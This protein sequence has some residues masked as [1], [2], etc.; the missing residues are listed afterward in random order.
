MPLLPFAVA[1]RWREETIISGGAETA[2]TAGPLLFSRPDAQDYLEVAAWYRGLGDYPSADAVLKRALKDL[3]ASALSPLVYYYLASD[4]RAEQDA[5]G[6]RSFAAEAAAASYHKVFPQRLSDA[7]VL[8]EAI[9]QSPV[10]ARAK[11]YLGNFFFA[12]GR[13]EDAARL[14][15]Q[16]L[17]GGFDYS[18]LDRNL[19]V[20]AWRV[21]RDRK[22]AA[23]F[24][25]QA[26]QL[27]PGDYRLYT[28]LD[29]IYAQ[30]GDTAHRA[31]VFA[32]AP[33]AVLDRDTVR[34]RRALLDVE[35][36]RYDQ[37]LVLLTGH[38]FKPWE[39]GEVVRRIYVRANLE[40]GKSKLRARR[41]QEAEAAFRRALEYPADLGVGKPDKP[42]DEQA[43]Y[44][45]GEALEAEG[46][47]NGARQA[48]GE[49]VAEGKA[50]GPFGRDSSGEPQV[51]AA[52]ALDKLG[53]TSEGQK[54]LND[55]ASGPS[56]KNAGKN[57][58]AYDFYVAGLAERARDHAHQA[59][60]DFRRA[61][62]LDPSLW[63]A[64]LE[65]GNRE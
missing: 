49:A 41:A 44:W 36:R 50:A 33:A 43:L 6:A 13:Y 23:G 59:G 26:L 18:V 32:K 42:H 54:I 31:D 51:C 47:R 9:A 17:G 52:L 37:A 22:A 39:G 45:L 46:K 11:Y 60:S 19:G 30:L 15:F 40:Q 10:D 27:A 24:Y 4:A 58:G 61:L 16:A 56:K 7:L 63:E 34:V 38:R 64:R 57:A 12:R 1:E 5:T 35:Q 14:W 55:L 2:E 48:W 28:D 29:E 3:P 20:Y 21:K 25:A 8:A 65:A 53:R 62:E